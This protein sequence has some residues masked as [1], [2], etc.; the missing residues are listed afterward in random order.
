MKKFAQR[1]G[2]GK[3]IL[4]RFI[5]F[6]GIIVLGLVVYNWSSVVSLVR[7]STPNVEKILPKP[8]TET[9]VFNQLN[10]Y[11]TANK[12]VALLRN[13][14]LDK[15]ALSRLGVIKNNQ[16]F[17]G[18]KTGITLENSVKNNGYNFSVVGEIAIDGVNGDTKL[19]DTW[20]QNLEQKKILD[21]KTF[22]EVGV[23]I[24]NEEFSYR[25]VVIMAKQ[26]VI[27]VEK[28][29]AGGYPSVSWG[30][31]E[32]WEAINKRRVELGVGPLSKRDELCTVASIRLNQLLTLGNL[33]G[34]AGFEPLLNRED[35]KSIRDKYNIAEYLIV[36]Y[37]TPAEA[38]AGWEHTLGHRGLLAGGEYVWG[39]VYSQDTFAVAIAAY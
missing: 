6:I 10:A 17:S 33:D 14:K 26:M 8:L 11:R 30:G 36:G 5:V 7:T 22:R 16:D 27:K 13:E 3:S 25:V 31:P 20:S 9:D 18:Q 37:L 2:V 15:A 29:G 35:L 12:M 34:H 4:N 32:L 23:A 38:V 21:D 19:A 1:G 28:L 24:V 39:C